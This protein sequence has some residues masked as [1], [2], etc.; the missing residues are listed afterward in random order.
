[1]ITAIC[2]NP[3]CG[4][5]ITV[6]DRYVGRKISCFVCRQPFQVEVVPTFDSHGPDPEGTGTP[7]LF[8][9]SPTSRPSATAPLGGLVGPVGG[10]GPPRRQLVNAPT[11]PTKP[12]PLP[13]RPGAGRGLRAAP[14]AV[15]LASLLVTVGCAVGIVLLLSPQRSETKPIDPDGPPPAAIERWAAITVESRGARLVVIDARRTP[16]NPEL[17]LVH[18]TSRDWKLGEVP[19]DGTR[20]P[21][22]DELE[23]ILDQYS[24]GLKLNEVPENNRLVACNEAVL[25]PT[26]DKTTPATREKLKGWVQAAVKKTLDREVDVVAAAQEAEYGARGCIPPTPAV[27]MQS[28]ALDIGNGST[29]YGYFDTPTDFKGDKFKTG[30]GAAHTEITA[31]AKVKKLDFALAAQ[32]WKPTNDEALRK[33]ADNVPPL[34]NHARYYLLG[35]APWVVTVLSHPEE[36]A[37]PIDARAVD[38]RL[39]TVDIDGVLRLIESKKDFDGVK[40]A[41][42]EKVPAAGRDQLG[43]ELSQIGRVF[44][45]EQMLAG[46]TLLKSIADTCN[47]GSKE[48]RFY[49][50]SLHAWPVGYIL[51]KGKF[52]Q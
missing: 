37:K 24:K 33:V 25:A 38:I 21:S 49:T 13:P 23:K 36:F 45:M 19:A 5:M 40:A 31:L 47:F 16:G 41:V 6:E 30:V 3:N 28:V 42:L 11:G 1:M 43:V 32:D 34:R 7:W 18:A 9:E 48:V 27:R 39:S 10:L 15:S 44:Q 50:R 12:P 2:P 8:G 51:V 52:E 35:G 26:G 46:A 14:T 29:K 4:Q 17:T 20:P 22:F